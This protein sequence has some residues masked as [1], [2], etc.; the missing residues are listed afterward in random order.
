MKRFHF[1]RVNESGLT[2]EAMSATI[3]MGEVIKIGSHAQC[4][5]R[6]KD[7][8]N[9]FSMH[10][11][12]ELVEGKDG[13]PTYRINNCGVS[14][15][16]LRVNNVPVDRSFRL[17]VGDVIRVGKTLLRLDAID[18]AED[19]SVSPSQV[20]ELPDDLSEVLNKVVAFLGLPKPDGSWTGMALAFAKWLA[21]AQAFVADPD[22]QHQATWTE[23]MLRVIGTRGMMKGN[24]EAVESCE[25]ADAVLREK[26]KRFPPKMVSHGDELSPD[27]ED[28]IRV[29]DLL[30]D[31]TK[32]W[33]DATGCNTPGEV[34]SVVEETNASVDVGLKNLADLREQVAGWRE[35]TGCA[36]PEAF[37]IDAEQ[38]NAQMQKT[39]RDLDDLQNQVDEWK[40]A[41]GCGDPEA[42]KSVIAELHNSVA[43]EHEKR[44][45]NN[46]SATDDRVAREQELAALRVQI[47]NWQNATNCSTPE[48]AHE[49]I[50]D[51]KHKWELEILKCVD[52]TNERN[53]AR[54]A[55]EL[56]G[57]KLTRWRM[58]TGYEDPGA[59]KNHLERE[60][61]LADVH[62][63]MIAERDQTIIEYAK[64]IDR[65]RDSAKEASKDCAD[66]ERA[67]ERAREETAAVKKEREC[68]DEVYVEALR[69]TIAHIRKA[70]GGATVDR[71]CEI[72]KTALI[73]LP[74]PDGVA[75]GQK[76]AFVFNAIEG[77]SSDDY[78]F[79]DPRSWEAYTFKK[80]ELSNQSG[81]IYLGTS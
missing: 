15:M 45:A 27:E 63:R 5:I 50:S 24:A 8:H 49:L 37:L 31:E 48:E 65:L 52:V 20:R 40:K 39:Y 25:I 80:T 47:I 68:Y 36:S 73:P 43:K 64:E 22:G 67:T 81:A 76:W 2:L 56:A 75:P 32:A 62:D 44:R 53:I 71:I 61:N 35:A 33:R 60:A 51:I 18:D 9:V 77:E 23:T 54:R 42:A 12:I 70:F 13:A 72:G 21:F 74:K 26:V 59:Y 69:N 34:A 17:E 57:E 66:A 19:K 29:M 46:Q 4:A 7:D 38:H 1:A 11:T 10:A 30:L 78:E 58:V 41:T 79:E 55:A 16:L 3:R 28:E 6:V 14:A